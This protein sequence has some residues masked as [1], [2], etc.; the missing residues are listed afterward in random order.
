MFMGQTGPYKHLT[1]HLPSGS[2]ISVP[3]LVSVL[4]SVLMQFIPQVFIFMWVKGEPFYFTHAF[5]PEDDNANMQSFEN[6]VLF[7]VAIF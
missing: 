1:Q 3:V 5:D 2:L 7:I 6:T 4:G